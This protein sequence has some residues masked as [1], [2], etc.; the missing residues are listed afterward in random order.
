MSEVEWPE[1]NIQSVGDC[2]QICVANTQCNG[3]HY[4]GYSDPWEQGKAGGHCYLKNGVTKV[5]ANLG[6]GR[7]RY[8]GI[9]KKGAWCFYELHI[10]NNISY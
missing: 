7:D 2:A 4:Y 9:C 3:F 10:V 6:D 8:S 1:Q 5:S